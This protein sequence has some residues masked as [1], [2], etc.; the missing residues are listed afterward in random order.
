VISNFLNDPFGLH[1][2]HL[3]C[4]QM[5]ARS[6]VVFFSALIFIR[7]AGIRTLGRQTSF[8]QL[9]ALIIGSILGR[10]VVTGQSFFGNLAAVLVIVLFHRFI[11]WLTF[12]SHKLGNILKG[13][14]LPLILDGQKYEENMTK[15]YITEEDI[16]ESLHLSLN[17]DKTDNIKAVYLER[18]GEIS[19]IKVPKRPGD[20]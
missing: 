19:F 1:A 9:T 12:K 6:L 20:N 13:K 5:I 10:A 18:S 11:A 2:E 17:L 7:I 14:P 4:L 16:K 3:I 8:D 15:E